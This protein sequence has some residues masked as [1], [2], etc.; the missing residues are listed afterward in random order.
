MLTAT[1][2]CPKCGAPVRIV[3]WPAER[4][5]YTDKRCD[6]PVRFGLVAEPEAET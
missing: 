6:C 2:D 3:A 5:T 1:V 4:V